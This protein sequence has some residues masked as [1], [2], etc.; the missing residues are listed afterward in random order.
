MD[1][2]RREAVFEPIR[3]IPKSNNQG[4]NHIKFNN[5]NFSKNFKLNFFFP[6]RLYI[7]PWNNDQAI[8]IS[9]TNNKAINIATKTKFLSDAAIDVSFSSVWNDTLLRSIL[10]TFSIWGAA[11]EVVTLVI[12]AA[13]RINNMFMIRSNGIALFLND[14]RYFI[15]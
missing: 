2:T 3:R 1:T 14:F 15:F 7:I 5:K 13:L 6:S 10:F 11:I 4:I 12:P 8:I 9:I